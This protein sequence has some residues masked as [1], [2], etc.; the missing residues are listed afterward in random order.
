MFSSFVL[1]FLVVLMSPVWW[2]LPCHVSP[3][4]FNI[5]FPR[6]PKNEK[7][8]NK[9]CSSHYFHILH[10]VERIALVWNLFQNVCG[11]LKHIYTMFMS[12]VDP[13]VLIMGN[14]EMHLQ[15][16]ATEQSSFE[17]FDHETEKI[18]VI[19]NCLIYGR[20]FTSV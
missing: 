6:S 15:L 3:S 4:W 8:N 10:I 5:R 20:Q 19:S 13:F 1:F 18:Q 9:K 14:R 16:R 7:K 11:A 2:G 12:S 17:V